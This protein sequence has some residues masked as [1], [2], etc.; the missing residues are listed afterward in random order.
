MKKLFFGICLLGWAFTIQAQTIF[1]GKIF[2]SDSVTT[3][4]GATVEIQHIGSVVT[5]EKGE[6]EFSFFTSDSGGGG[7]VIVQ[8]T[9]LNGGLGAACFP[10]TIEKDEK[11][12]NK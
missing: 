1:K 6:A 2:Q 5:N 9:D 7:I 11:K 8:G 12:F 10:L 3:V 4:S